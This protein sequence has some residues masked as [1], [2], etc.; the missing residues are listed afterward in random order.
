MIRIDKSLP[1]YVSFQWFELTN[2][3]TDTNFLNDS[4][5]RITL[6]LRIILMIRIDESLHWSELFQW[7]VSLNWYE[8]FQWFESTNRFNNI[9]IPP[10]IQITSL[11]QINE[12]VPNFQ[13]HRSTEHLFTKSLIKPTK[14]K[15]IPEIYFELYEVK[16]IAIRINQPELQTVTQIPILEFVFKW[17]KLLNWI[18]KTLY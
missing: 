12:T 4:I 2:H 5:Q 16:L 10:I 11:I 8:S 7:F 15:T 14:I 17:F 6:L 13:R 1:W 18:N 9:L 3:F